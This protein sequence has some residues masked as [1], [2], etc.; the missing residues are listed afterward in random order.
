MCGPFLSASIAIDKFG[1]NIQQAN[2]LN[3]AVDMYAEYENK[4]KAAVEDNM[5]EVYINSL[6]A[7]SDY[8]EQIFRISLASVMPTDEVS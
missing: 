4:L 5:D 3:E 1:Q 2:L 6:R 8:Y 7:E